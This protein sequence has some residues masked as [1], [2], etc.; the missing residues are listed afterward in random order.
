MIVHLNLTWRQK[1]LGQKAIMVSS[2]WH[3]IYKCM[4]HVKDQQGMM[5]I[6]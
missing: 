1:S 2:T 4:I 6:N 3:Q 5:H